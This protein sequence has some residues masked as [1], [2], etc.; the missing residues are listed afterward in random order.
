MTGSFALVR[1]YSAPLFL[2]EFAV[3]DIDWRA[4]A[5][6][7][8]NTVPIRGFGVYQL[9]GDFVAQHRLALDLIV[10]NEPRAHFEGDVQFGGFFPHIDAVVSKNGMVC[11]DTVLHV[12]G[13]PVGNTCGGIAGL[14]CQDNQFCKTPTGHCYPDATGVCTTIPNACP[15]I[16]D[17]VCGCDGV[18]YGNECEAEMASMS[19]AHL[20]ECAPF[21]GSDADCSAANQFCKFPEGACGVAAIPGR[22]T[23]IPTACPAIWDPVC[24]CDGQ[25][26]G[27]EC[28]S[29]MARVSVAH[30]GPCE[31]ACSQVQNLPPCANGLFCLYPEGTCDNGIVAGV[32]TPIPLGCPDVWDPVCGC[33]DVTYGN[34]CDARA[35]GVSIRS[36]G[37][38]PRYCTNVA[39]TVPCEP[40]EF[41]KF[42]IGTCGDASAVGVCTNIPTGGC[43]EN[44]NP[45]CG[46]DGVTYGNECEADAAAVSI[47][48]L[49]ECAGTPCSATRI[50]LPAVNAYCHHSPLSIRIDLT[51]PAGTTILALEDAPPAGWIVTDISHEGTFDQVNGKVK[52]G[53]FFAPDIPPYVNY[54]VRPVNDQSIA[55]CFEGTVSADGAGEPICGQSCIN[56]S[57]PPFMAADTPQP[58]CPSCPVGDCTTCPNGTCRDGRISLCEVIGYACAWKRGCNDDLAGMARAA[59]VWRHGECYCWDPSDANWFPIACPPP[60]S[61]Y[62]PADD[63]TDAG[64]AAGEFAGAKAAVNLYGSRTRDRASARQIEVQVRFTPPPG[65]TTMAFEIDV[66]T[67]W[68]VA[69]VDNGGQWDPDHRKIKWGPFFDN[70]SPVVSFELMRDRDPRSLSRPAPLSRDDLTGVLGGRVVFDGVMYPMAVR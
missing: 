37:E 51:P 48:D 10:G 68:R 45:V 70:V 42:P 8:A 26:Y 67:G 5:P 19:I 11:N 38:C 14:P 24:G 2:E 32:C 3:I 4:H 20:G 16:W 41:C 36:R 39:G 35:A 62:C 66:A 47:D 60:A 55:A 1:V 31:H 69:N 64:P 17:P 25:T 40:D 61:G 13:D 44:Y 33:D 30:R 59:Y 12:V 49:G 57:C 15:A 43:P 54:K 56:V 21:C 46:C 50:I 22:C 28:E 27:N 9:I 58:P 53:P 65:A 18:T 6:S 52:W 7:I 63:A 29:D 34:E 23:T